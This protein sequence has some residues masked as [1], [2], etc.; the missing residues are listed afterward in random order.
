MVV[1]LGDA[2][3]VT[4]TDGALAFTADSRHYPIISVTTGWVTLQ[5][6]FATVTTS[7]IVEASVIR[8]SH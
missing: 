1:G 8:Q 4:E 3:K 5:C 2:G 6:P 7:N